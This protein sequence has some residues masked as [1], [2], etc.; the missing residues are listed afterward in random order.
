M[1]KIIAVIILLS[2]FLSGCSARENETHPSVVIVN[3]NPN[4]VYDKS[5]MSGSE[6]NYGGFGISFKVHKGSFARGELLIL[7]IS[8][9]NNTGKSYKWRGSSSI[10]HPTNVKLWCV[11]EDGSK[12]SIPHRSL[13]DTED[14][15]DN[16]VKHG[17]SNTRTYVFD[18]PEDALAGDCTLTCS[19]Q[20]DP[21]NC[22]RKDTIIFE[23]YFR[24]EE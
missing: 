8:L 10:F 4:S 11:K 2:V 18:I 13:P 9:I 22:G 20:A 15:C 19:F 7:S 21:E 12:Y 1:K 6:P 24:L 3:K 14:I 16:E 23:G 17:E 5:N